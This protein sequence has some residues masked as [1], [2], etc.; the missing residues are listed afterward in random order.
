MLMDCFGPFKSMIY[1]G[2]MLGYPRGG[3]EIMEVD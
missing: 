1:V 2:Q 3:I